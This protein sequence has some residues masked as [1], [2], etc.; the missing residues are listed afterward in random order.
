MRN[1]LRDINNNITN[2]LNALLILR[3]DIINCFKELEDIADDDTLS[4]EDY[5]EIVRKKCKRMK[6]TL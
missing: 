1:Q 6:S 2:E 3:I 5:R 4:C